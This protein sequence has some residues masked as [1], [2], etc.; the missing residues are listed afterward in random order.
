MSQFGCHHRA[1]QCGRLTQLKCAFSLS[2]RLEAKIKV[3][4]GLAFS[5]VP[6]LG[7]QMAAFSLLPSVCVCALNYS[8]K[9]TD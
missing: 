1:P 5:E 8:C 2:W 9:D 7:M 3:S 4:A 6:L